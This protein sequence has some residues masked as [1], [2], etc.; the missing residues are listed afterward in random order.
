[1]IKRLLTVILFFLIFFNNYFILN[2]E[3]PVIIDKE[4]W[5]PKKWDELRVD[6]ENNIGYLIHFDGSYL[7][8]PMLT[9][10]KRYVYY[11]GMHY[12][13]GTPKKNWEVKSVDYKG[14]YYTFGPTGRF[15]RLFDVKNGMDQRTSYGIHSHKYIQEMLDSNNHYR[16][17]GCILVTDDVLDL[18]YQTYL[19][20]GESLKVE[21][22]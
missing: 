1:M 20:N 21:T 10:Q 5:K 17:Y 19:A 6:T 2:A 13:A 3:E 14:D 11:L 12:F 22:Y 16:S 4:S 9:G 7:S 15:L 18:I 8:F